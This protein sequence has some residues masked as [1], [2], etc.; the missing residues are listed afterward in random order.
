MN[1]TYDNFHEIER[2][3]L[4][5]YDE[6]VLFSNYEEEDLKRCYILE[7]FQTHIQ[8]MILGDILANGFDEELID[9]IGDVDV[10]L[11]DEYIDFYGYRL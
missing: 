11:P 8:E 9:R 4:G 6:T 2:D 10:S 5:S 1:K 7:I 3:A